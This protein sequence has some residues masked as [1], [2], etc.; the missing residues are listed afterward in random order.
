MIYYTMQLIIVV[1]AVVSVLSRRE[2][3]ICTIASFS[4][5]AD[6]LSFTLLGPKI[7][8]AL[9]VGILMIPE[10]IFYA[11]SIVS[12]SKPTRL[13]LMGLM[14]FVFTWVLYGYIF[15]WADTSGA[16]PWSQRAAGRATIAG[17]RH[18]SEL[19]LLF[20]IAKVSMRDENILKWIVKGLT[21]GLA[22]NVSFAVLGLII[23]SRFSEALGVVQLVE[24]FNGLNGEPRVLG[25]MA[26]ITL[27]CAVASHKTWGTGAI[28][29]AGIAAVTLVLSASTSA[30]LSLSAAVV[31]WALITPLSRHFS[32]RTAVIALALIG[33]ALTMVYLSPGRE[34]VEVRLNSMLIAPD[35]ESG[36]PMFVA[37]L[38]VFDRSAMRFLLDRPEY[39]LI[40]TGPSLVSLPASAYVPALASSIYGARVDSVPHAGL[41]AEVASSGLLGLGLWVLVVVF[42][43]RDVFRLRSEHARAVGHALGLVALFS[44]LNWSLAFYIVVGLG[45]G[46]ARAARIRAAG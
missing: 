28:I 21:F 9:L 1:V 7:P 46:T 26:A 14:L 13:I 37:G 36:E 20:Y 30:V 2:A 32:R 43:L 34:Y 18:I 31:I 5:T 39:M 6:V 40:G 33:V 35:R 15:P 38:E 29:G 42:I 8:L 44:L 4:I 3:W 16:R 24:R 17:I 41:I 27:L 12:T 19:S 22:V 25:R 10:S 45:L 23:G 11:R